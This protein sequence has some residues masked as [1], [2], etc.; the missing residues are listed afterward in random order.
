MQVK[1]VLFIPLILCSLAFAQPKVAVGAIGEEPKLGILK[2]L[3]SQLTK[4]LV[5][6]GKYTA[7]DR[8]EAILKQLGKEL[9]YQRSGAVNEQQIREF[10]QQFGVQYMCIVESSEVMGSF[11]LEAKLV[12]VETA[13]IASIG[14]TPSDLVNIGDLMAASEEIVRQL[15]GSK[16]GVKNNYGSGVF[17]NKNAQPNSIASKIE[18]I[19]KQK[20]SISEGTCVGGAKA[21]IESDNKPLCSEGMVGITCKANVSL[22]ITQCKG[23]KKSILKGSIIGSDKYSEDIAVKQMMRKIENADF[24]NNWMKEL[25]KWSKQ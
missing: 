4:A 24:W 21:A 17:L 20:V 10:G 25:E 6:S 8:S 18:E 23:G 16:A 11:M 7:L 5:N 22:V 14:N 19:F 13:E 15:L 1:K 9:A 3:S 2:A 12:D